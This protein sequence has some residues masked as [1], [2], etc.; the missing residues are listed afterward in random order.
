MTV[1]NASKEQIVLGVHHRFMHMQRNTDLLFG[2]TSS[3]MFDDLKAD[4]NDG[5]VLAGQVMNCSLQ[6]LLVTGRKPATN[7]ISHCA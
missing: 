2:I 5:W 1:A 6:A 3:K 7:N 4:V